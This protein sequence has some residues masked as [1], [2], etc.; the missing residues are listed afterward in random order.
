MIGGVAVYLVFQGI[1]AIKLFR[2]SSHV[3]ALSN[4]VLGLRAQGY[5]QKRWNRKDEEEE[6]FKQAIQRPAP[7]AQRFANDPLVYDPTRE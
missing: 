7:Q 5:V 2:L 4:T 3:G 1:L 6:F